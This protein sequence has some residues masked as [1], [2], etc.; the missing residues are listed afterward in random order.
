M[1]FG[2]L[3]KHLRQQRELT[4]P[5]LAEQIGIEQSYLSKLE[6]DK[7]CPSADIF[8]RVLEVLQVSLEEMLAQLSPKAIRNQLKGVPQV[9]EHIQAVVKQN[10]QSRKRWLLMSAIACV[11]ALVAIAS[12]SLQ[13]IFTDKVF[14]Y[15][16]L[17]ITFDGESKDKIRSKQN[18]GSVQKRLNEISVL[19][20]KFRGMH[21][22]VALTEGSRRFYLT[23][24]HEIDSLANRILMIIGL[25]L[26]VGGVFGIFV[27]WR[28]N[29]WQSKLP[30]T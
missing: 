11:I 22:D 3:L 17:G 2:Q 4:Q 9:Q 19:T 29:Q 5:D 10:I 12:S 7:A 8:Q 15:E 24:D 26:G 1:N 30:L 14:Q 16:S 28:M 27:D 23:S 21:Y 18:D 25:L 20:S 13:L 6:N